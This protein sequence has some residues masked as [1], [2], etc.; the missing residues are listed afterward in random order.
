MSSPLQQAPFG[1]L[2]A[3]GL[4]A[5]GRNPNAMS[6]EVRPV[7]ASEPFWFPPSI[8]QQTFS[9]S[10]PIVDGST[11]NLPVPGNEAW[12]IYALSGTLRL[13]AG[14]AIVEPVQLTLGWQENLTTAARAAVFHV[15][16]TWQPAT[17]AEISSFPVGFM[18]AQPIVL[19]PNSRVSMRVTGHLT[20]AG[21]DVAQVTALVFPIPV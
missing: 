10:T 14:A 5:L 7:V 21:V 19:P 6:D 18:P 16:Q 15:G 9:I 13:T 4:K 8:R 17:L 2:G 11:Y 20:L 12:W 1:F 3:F